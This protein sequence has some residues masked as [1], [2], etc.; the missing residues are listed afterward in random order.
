MCAVI[1]TLCVC[2]AHAPAAADTEARPPE[3]YVLDYP[4]AE[5][6]CPPV[7]TYFAE[8]VR[9]FEVVRGRRFTHQPNGGFGLP[10]VQQVGGR[11]LL[12]L[13]ADVGWH[14]VG[15]P[16]YAMA[17]GV[18]R[19]SEGPGELAAE[20]KSSAGDRAG[21]KRP[22]FP[23]GALLWGN[24]V[25]IEHH[26][27]S[28]EYFNSIYGHLGVNRLVKP[29]DVVQAGQQIGTI[30]ANRRDINGGY[31]PHL[32][33]AV[34]QGRLADPGCT[35][36]EIREKPEDAPLPAKLKTLG[37]R[38]IELEYPAAVA[39]RMQQAARRTIRL[40]GRVYPVTVRDGRFFAAAQMLWDVKSR[41]GFAVVG[42]DL[43]TEGWPDPTAFLRQHGADENPAPFH[44]QRSLR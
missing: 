36:Y 7:E 38:E 10:I 42:Y 39:E 30:G 11:N 21:G 23:P 18:V 5:Q 34:R 19:V 2:S 31:T 1:L 41:P 8:V 27:P 14:G 17:A 25:M 32:H 37:E 33:F 3:R 20:L 22:A 16:V 12:H 43:S 13:G 4:A 9:S 40:G 29:G 15:A 35:L 6:F 24:A 44:R 26:L 28:G